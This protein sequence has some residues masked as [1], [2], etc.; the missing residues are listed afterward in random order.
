MVDLN[1]PAS[2][3]GGQFFLLCHTAMPAG[4]SEG[5][6]A[7]L[8]SQLP[9]P[10]EQPNLWYG[11]GWLYVGTVVALWCC[12]NLFPNIPKCMCKISLKPDSL[13]YNSLAFCI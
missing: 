6:T 2:L 9:T 13:S 1:P 11:Q 5:H 7:K 4:V 10:P 8:L 12:L 3:P